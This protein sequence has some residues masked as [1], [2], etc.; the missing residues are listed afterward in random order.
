ML[1]ESVRQRREYLYR[2]NLEKRHKEVKEKKEQLRQALEEGKQI[3]TELRAEHELLVGLDLEDTKMKSKIH[4]NVD[5]EYRLAGVKDPKIAI[6]TSRDPSSRL[7]QFLKEMKLI[8]P[9]GERLNRGNM[10]L[11][12]LVELCRAHEVTDLIILHEHRGVPTAMVVSHL[13]HGPTA[14]FNIADIV[15]R[16]D[17]PE[18]PPAM[19]EMYPHLIFHDF[20]TPLGQR[21]ANILKHLFP[22]PSSSTSRVL[23]FVNVGDHIA[24][25]HHVWKDGGSANPDGNE[26][27]KKKE[28][29]R[30]K[31]APLHHNPVL[32]EIGPRFTMRLFRIDLGT[33]D[34]KGIESEWVL[35]NYINAP[36][37][38]LS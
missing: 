31:D 30:K 19:S 21:T 1:R 8:F 28:G 38:A 34:Q 5:D 2:K 14:Y 9:G 18:R 7:V 35:R 10:L 13:P 29:K 17:L 27:F 3:P 22:V 16:H 6:T 37:F 36:K 12:S 25:R 20:A 23:S 33:I 11:A 26:E 15:L 4:T 24:F 32:M